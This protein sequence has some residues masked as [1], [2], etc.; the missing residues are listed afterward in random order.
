MDFIESEHPELD[1]HYQVLY[2]IVNTEISLKHK[3]I[4]L[5]K[6]Y[7][8]LS[9]KEMAE[10]FHVSHDAVRTRL[11]RARKAMRRHIMENKQSF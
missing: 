9:D 7:M 3:S 11:S 5:M 2:D 8:Q 1:D 4:L 10:V 6:Y